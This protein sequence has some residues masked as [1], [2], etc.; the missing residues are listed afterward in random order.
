MS[1]FFTKE[2][3]D[4]QTEDPVMAM[5]PKMEERMLSMQT[6]IMKTDAKFNILT[7]KIVKVESKYLNLETN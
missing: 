1:T 2:K 4:D 5:L 3:Y 6:T 7:N